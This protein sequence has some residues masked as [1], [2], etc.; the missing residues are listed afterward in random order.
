M[1]TTMRLSRIGYAMALM[2]FGA[3]A[4]QSLQGEEPMQNVDPARHPNIAA[5]QELSRQAY[6]KMTAAQAANEFDLEGHAERAKLLLLQANQEMK[7][8][9]LASNRHGG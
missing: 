4:Q 1:T 5:A 8:A 7:R 6:D 9:A 2:T 3:C